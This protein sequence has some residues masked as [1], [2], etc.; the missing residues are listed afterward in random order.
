MSESPGPRNGRMN[1]SVGDQPAV[2]VRKAAACQG[3]MRSEPK[4]KKIMV[5]PRPQ[6]KFAVLELYCILAW[7]ELN[8][9]SPAGEQLTGRNRDTKICEG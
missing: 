9:E 7:L 2:K 4:K 1:N 3:V 5:Q 6:Q 8:T